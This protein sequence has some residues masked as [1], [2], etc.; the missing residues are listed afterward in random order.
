MLL[1]GPGVR[2][3]HVM[4]FGME[5]QTHQGTQ[6]QQQTNLQSTEEIQQPAVTP[7]PQELSPE[8][9]L[10]TPV[11]EHVTDTD[12]SPA[13]SR[14]AATIQQRRLQ[15]PSRS[16]R[17]DALLQKIIDKLDGYFE[18]DQDWK[19]KFLTEIIGRNHEELVIKRIS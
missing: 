15:P 14:P 19:D 4:S 8:P 2:P 6:Q 9:T 12:P 13:L 18:K 10:I 16:E 7:D 1:D 11:P 17:V 3:K 5:M